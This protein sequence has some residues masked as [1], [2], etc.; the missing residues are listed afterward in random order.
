MPHPSNRRSRRRLAAAAAALSGVAL[1]PACGLLGSDAVLTTEVEPVSLRFEG[2]TYL[3]ATPEGVLVR[4]GEHEVVLPEAGDG[5]WLP[6]GRALVDMG[7]RHTRLRVVDPAT[8]PVG[9]LLRVPDEPPGRSVTQVNLLARSGAERRVTAY[10]TALEALWTVALPET[11]NPD[12]TSMNGLERNYYGVVPTIG[13]ITFV[14][15]HDGSEWYDEGD[16]GVARIEGDKIE[17]VLV[18]E[19]IVA[20]YLSADGSGLLALR[21]QEGEP[22]GGCEV[23][24]EIV[25]I[26]PETGELADYGVPD[27]YDRTWRVDAMDK[28]GGRV[29]VRFEQVDGTG[30]HRSLHLVGTYVY[31]DGDWSLL[32]GSDTEVTW[33]QA[34][35]DRV[36]A[37]PRPQEPADRDGY[38]LFWVHHDQETPLPGELR[39][40]VG[41]WTVTGSVAGQL[42][43]PA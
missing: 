13:G 1:L 41:R 3:A 6:D 29:A 39:G 10:S 36:V 2:P 37:R 4:S 15:W 27:G 24:Q 17:N 43:P 40:L 26:D 25:E 12:A 16:Y 18:N 8:G 14:Q 9:P 42:L 30:G 21:Q 5:R 23:E 33:W 35:G 38:A 28:V 7:G 20:L 22:C 34:D 32:E 19:R 11:D 31:E